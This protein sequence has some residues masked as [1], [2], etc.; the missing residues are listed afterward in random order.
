M[1]IL[2]MM[3]DTHKI[4]LPLWEIGV[5]KQEYDV[6]FSARGSEIPQNPQIAPNGDL[7]N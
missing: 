3:R 7:Y 5:A 4:S 6:R 1:G 2:K